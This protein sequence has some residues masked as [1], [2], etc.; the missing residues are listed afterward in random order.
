MGGG[1]HGVL[2][3][4]NIAELVALKA[5]DTS[6]TVP[7][8]AILWMGVHD[9]DGINSFSHHFRRFIFRRNANCGNME[10]TINENN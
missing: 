6:H 4:E 1:S 9:N 3:A 10:E 2:S 5:T 7:T 8:V